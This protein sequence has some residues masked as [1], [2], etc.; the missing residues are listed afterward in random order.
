[1]LRGA[2][3]L[4]RRRFAEVRLRDGRGRR[5]RYGPQSVQGRLRDRPREEREEGGQE[6]ARDL[7][8]GRERRRR[9]GRPAQGRLH[10]RW[11]RWNRLLLSAFGARDGL[12]W[13]RRSSTR[14]DPTVFSGR[15]FR[16]AGPWWVWATSVCGLPERGLG[17]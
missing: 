8:G 12:T 9:R 16:V 13:R 3:P 17:P 11:G 1:T 4:G 14:L 6:G 7:Q 2:D 10:A 15:A 5:R